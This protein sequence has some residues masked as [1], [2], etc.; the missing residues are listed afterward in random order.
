MHHPTDR[1]THIT[2]FVTPVVE[3][4]LEWE[5]TQWVHYGGSIRWPIAPQANALA[6]ELHLAPGI[7]EWCSTIHKGCFLWTHYNLWIKEENVLFNDVLNTFYLWLYDSERGN[8]LLSVH[9]LIFLISSK[10][11]PPQTVHTMAFSTP[12]VEQWLNFEMN[13]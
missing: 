2:A 13:Y 6:M 10:S 1:I 8:L 5:I 9:G 12:V 4:W 3:H 7:S 11:P